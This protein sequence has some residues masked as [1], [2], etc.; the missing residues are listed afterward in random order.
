MGII[1][2]LVAY[3]CFEVQE[4]I[5]NMRKAYKS[6]YL[7]VIV[8]KRIAIIMTKEKVGVLFFKETETG[9]WNWKITG[10]DV[11]SRTSGT[12]CLCSSLVM[13]SLDW[14]YSIRGDV[15]IVSLCQSL[16]T[17]YTILIF[18]DISIYLNLLFYS[19]PASSLFCPHVI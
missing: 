19:I 3:G 17:F 10:R 1:K 2:V 4:L 11:I 15:S 18:W 9:L 13:F 7:I 12:S 14:C 8:W 6:D 16:P 5:Q